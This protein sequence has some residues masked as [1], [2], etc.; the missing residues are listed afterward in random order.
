MENM[1]PLSFVRQFALS[2]LVVGILLAM[3]SMFWTTDVANSKED[4]SRM[5]FG[6]PLDFFDVDQSRYDPPYPYTMKYC[7]PWEC[8]MQSVS[9]IDLAADVLFFGSIFAVLSFA[10]FSLFPHTWSY[11]RFLSLKYVL[12]ALG[13]MAIFFIIA[14]IFIL[15]IITGG[16]ILVN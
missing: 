6:F 13:S 2:F 15:P 7:G 5:S 11:A 4:L 3:S 14:V 8:P 9:G 10:G 12:M 1:Q 16:P